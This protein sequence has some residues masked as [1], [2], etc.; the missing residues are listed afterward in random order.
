MCVSLAAKS[1]SRR[2]R[3]SAISAAAACFGAALQRGAGP[4]PGQDQP[5]GWGGAQ[6]RNS[7]RPCWRRPAG[8]TPIAGSTSAV[9][10]PKRL[11]AAARAARA[12][13]GSGPGRAQV[14]A[15]PGSALPRTASGMR[16][17]CGAPRPAGPLR[18]S[19]QRRAA[20]SPSGS[21]GRPAWRRSTA[22]L[23]EAWRH[24][25]PGPSGA[26]RKGP[27]GGRGVGQP[28]L[29]D[30][31]PVCPNC[32]PSRPHPRPFHY[33]GTA[34]EEAAAGACQG[35]VP[36]SI[37]L[38][39]APRRGPTAIGVERECEAEASAQCHLHGL[40]FQCHGGLSGHCC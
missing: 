35:V 29:R 4:G 27:P 9:P 5:A 1:R 32:F 7:P 21:A 24:R 19:Q 11:L 23:P 38:H 2:R 34:G 39:A 8:P 3:G 20:A 17:A 31:L 30:Y 18:P 26:C 33:L 10:T 37:Y 40:G 28:L 13:H 36:E 22:L 6:A 14:G 12:A 15:R 25:L 16:G